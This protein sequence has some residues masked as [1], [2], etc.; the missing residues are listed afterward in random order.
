MNSTAL[1][2][3]GPCYRGFGVF[4]CRGLGSPKPPFW[5]PMILRVG[6]YQY[7]FLLGIYH[8]VYHMFF[9]KFIEKLLYICMHLGMHIVLPKPCMWTTLAVF[10]KDV[11]FTMN[12]QHICMF[13]YIYPNFPQ[14]W[15]VYL[16]GAFMCDFYLFKCRARNWKKCL[17]VCFDSIFSFMADLT[18]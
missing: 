4:F 13:I 1:R 7:Y 16:E 11:Q 3:T 14:L 12:A 8:V 9:P 15:L 18:I 2:S 10:S 17:L 6:Q 5:D